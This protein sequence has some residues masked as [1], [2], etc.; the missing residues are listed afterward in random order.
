MPILISI[1]DDCKPLADALKASVASVAR[2]RRRGDGGRA[3]DYAQVERE[4]GADTAVVERAAHQ[5]VLSALD[6][7]TPTVRILMMARS[8]SRPPH[9]QT[10]GS[11]PPAYATR[12][13]E[14]SPKLGTNRVE[15]RRKASAHQLRPQQVPMVALRLH[16]RWRG[17]CPVV[18]RRR[19]GVSRRVGTDPPAPCGTRPEHP[20]I[21]HH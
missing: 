3:V 17:R 1:P 14:V 2:A 12:S 11:K 20:V 6:I 8:R 15:R 4:L 9:A 10:S 13:G 19:I 5:A 21:Q 7:D 18:A 16:R